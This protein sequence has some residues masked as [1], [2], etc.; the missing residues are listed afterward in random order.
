MN[1]NCVTVMYS[2]SKAMQSICGL[3]ATTHVYHRSA[4][5]ATDNMQMNECGFVPIKFYLWTLKFESPMTF[6]SYKIY[7]FNFLN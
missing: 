4:T 6:K 3:W 1:A 5:E 2:I 7:S